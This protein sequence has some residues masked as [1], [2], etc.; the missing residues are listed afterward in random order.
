MTASK[1]K[2]A[3]HG[4]ITARQLSKDAR[5]ELKSG[6]KRY[7]L[8]LACVAVP[9]DLLG[10]TG[11]AGPFT[12]I[13]AFLLVASLVMNV[14]IVWAVVQKERTGV[15]PRPSEAYYDGSVAFV[16]FVLVML[17]L[18]VLAIPAT[19]GLVFYAMAQSAF[20][21]TGASIGEEFLIGFVCFLPGLL[22]AWWFA[23][24]G[25]AITAV[26]ASDL[27]PM[28][29]LR[30]A[31]R[32]TLGRFWIVV[33]RYLGLFATL[34]LLAIPVA[35]ITALLGFLKLTPL[36][37]LFFQ[38]CT[39]FIALPLTNIYLL[40]LYRALEPKSRTERSQYEPEPEAA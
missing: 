36:A 11:T 22:S 39:T 29:A 27:R 13:G 5:A 1:K 9:S 6:W 40:N 23:R 21:T 3:N 4:F 32:L 30:Y 35:L 16:R 17:A 25:L 26:V 10:M 33:R 18:L 8:I 34:L 38:L 37:V 15:I 19:I 14:A 7:A 2:P 12:T 31:R 20:Q 24:F 28:A